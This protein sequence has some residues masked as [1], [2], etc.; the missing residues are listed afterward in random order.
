MKTASLIL[1]FIGMIAIAGGAL[2]YKASRTINT[3][4]LYTT[5]KSGG[6][7]VGACV[8]PTQLMYQAHPAGTVIT[9]VSSAQIIGV[10]TCTSRVIQSL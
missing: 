9:T 6:H 8:N 2:A 10:A 4:Y 1:A 3:F 5:T 7:I